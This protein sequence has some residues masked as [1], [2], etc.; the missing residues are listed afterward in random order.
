MR[1]TAPVDGVERPTARLAGALHLSAGEM[2]DQRDESDERD[3]PDGNREPAFA[4]WFDPLTRRQLGRAALKV[5]GTIGALAALNRLAPGRS[6]ADTGAGGSQAG[7]WPVD[8]APPPHR[9]PAEPPELPQDLDSVDLQRALGWDVSV[10]GGLLPV[11]DRSGVDS[12]GGA[13]WRDLL[14]PNPERSLY[15]P[16]H[17]L[18][19]PDPLLA[20]YTPL[21]TAWR[22]YFRATLMQALAQ[23]ELARH[24]TPVFTP[25]MWATY[26]RGRALAAQLKGQSPPT[27]VMMVAD[28]PGPDSVALGAALAGQL[29]LV[30][31]FDNWPHPSGIVPAQ[32]TLGA[33][34]YYARKVAEERRHLQTRL[35]APPLFLLDRSRL[36]NYEDAQERFDNRYL[37]DLPGPDELRARGVRTV[38]YIVPDRASLPELDDLNE[39]FVSYVENGIEVTALPLD[40]FF[41][42]TADVVEDPCYYG[43]WP[44][45]GFGFFLNYPS[46]NPQ[47]PWLRR[48][49]H[50]PWQVGQLRPPVTRGHMPMRPGYRPM[51]R[52]TIPRGPARISMHASRQAALA[53]PTQGTGRTRVLVSQGRVTAVR[54]GRSGSFS[55]AGLGGRGGGGGRG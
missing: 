8:G 42:G 11:R 4:S 54:I 18:F 25:G 5:A 1:E 6:S 51:P 26:L 45:L 50:E 12:L 3:S 46:L 33:L 40:D 15:A 48:R 29:D 30:V 20:I 37:V 32:Q 35:P 49:H 34:L 13:A 55:R 52:H 16:V 2:A 7:G 14:R 28:L 10:P 53:T 31:T 38:V 23:P 19:V 17:E 27:S 36:A 43:G 44:G 9:D 39:V 47:E 24:M 41:S 21:Q 22:P